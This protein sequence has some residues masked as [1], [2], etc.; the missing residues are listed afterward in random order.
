M[1]ASEE[2]TFRGVPI[3]WAPSFV[4]ITATPG[5]EQMGA[6]LEKALN[7]MLHDN[8]NQWQARILEQEKGFYA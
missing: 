6:D 2:L 5:N 8:L 3:V 4:K 7:H 1:A